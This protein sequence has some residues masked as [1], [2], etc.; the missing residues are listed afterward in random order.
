MNERV[1]FVARYLQHD[2]P[3]TTLRASIG[4]SRKTGYKWVSATR[5]AR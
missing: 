1:K 5:L 2:E 3:F 4:V